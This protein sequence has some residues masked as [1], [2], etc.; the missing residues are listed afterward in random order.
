MLIAYP[1]SVFQSDSKELG[2]LFGVK[3]LHFFFYRFKK[4]HSNPQKLYLDRC[5]CI[6][7]KTLVEDKYDE[8]HVHC[9][10]ACFIKVYWVISGQLPTGQFLTG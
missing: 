9:T 8:I 1:Q 10:L 5:G 6:L 2:F 3:M 4:I 7:M